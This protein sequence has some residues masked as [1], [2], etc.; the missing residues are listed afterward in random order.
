MTQHKDDVMY[1][2]TKTAKIF[3][4]NRIQNRGRRH[5]EFTSGINFGHVAYFG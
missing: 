1:Q 4:V 2:S 3:S 5:L